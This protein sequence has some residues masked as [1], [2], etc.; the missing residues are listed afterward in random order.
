MSEYDE[1]TKG[2]IQKLKEM[3]KKEE[4]AEVRCS[5]YETLAS[6]G[7]EG[8]EVLLELIE[9]EKDDKAKIWAFEKM[10]EANK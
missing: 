9:I 5:I 6:F 2:Q 4:S 7:K 3:A 1:Q 8:R 10:S